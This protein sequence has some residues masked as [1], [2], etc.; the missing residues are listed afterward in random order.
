MQRLIFHTTISIMLLICMFF[1][2]DTKLRKKSKYDKFEL[3]SILHNISKLHDGLRSN[4]TQN[5]RHTY[6]YFK[7]VLNTSCVRELH[8]LKQSE[9]NDKSTMSFVKQGN[10]IVYSD[11]IYLHVPRE[12]KTG[13]ISGARTLNKIEMIYVSQST[14]AS[15]VWKFQFIV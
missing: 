10:K 1:M 15:L 7:D 3:E 12:E 5:P 6:I 2:Y 4:I 13:W 8:V 9:E 11:N 14:N